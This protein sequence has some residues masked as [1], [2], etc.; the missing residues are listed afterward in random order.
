M[1]DAASNGNLLFSGSTFTT[2]TLN[3]NTTYYVESE[4]GS[5]CKSTRT[6]VTVTIDAAPSSPTVSGTSI[7]SGQTAMLTPS[8]PSGVTFNWYD[9]ASNG[10]LLFSGSTF[11]TPTLNSNTTYYVESENGSGCKSTRTSVTVTIDAAPSSPTV[12]GTSICSGQTAMLTPSAPS[13]VTFNWYDAASNG[14]LL[15]S[16]STFTTPTLNSNTTYYVESENGSGCKSTRTSVTVTI[17]AAPS[18]P[19]V[20]G[21]SICSGQTAMLTPSAPSGVTFNWYDAASNGNLLF[22]GSTFTTPTLN[23]N[24]TYY[25]ESENGSGC[26]STRTSVTVTIDAARSSPTV[27]GTSICS[28]QTAMLTPSAPSGVTFNWY[29]AASNGN[30]LFSGSTFTTPTLNSNTTYYVESENGSGCKSTRTSVTVTIDAAPSSPTVIGTSICSGQ[31][32]ML[33]PSAPSGVTFNWYDAASNGNLLFSG[34]TFTTPT[35]NSN[36]TYYVESENGSGCKS[37]R[38]SVT[39]T[40]DA[41]PSSPTVIGTSICS[42]QTAMLTP[43]APSG[44]TFNWY[45]AASNGNLLFSGSTFTT[46]TLNSNT[47]YYVESENGSGC[48]STRTSVTVTIDAAPSSPTVSGTSICSG[49]T[50]M[51][52]PS[53]PSGVTFNWYDAASNGNLLFSGSTFTTPTLNS[54]TTYYVESENGS[55]CKSTRTSV[56]VTI[57]AAPSS[58]TVSGTSICSGQTAMLTPSAPSGV[59]FNW[60][61]AASNGNLLF[62]GSTFTT[63]TLNSNTTYY[64]ESENGSGCKSTRTSVTVTIDAAPSSPTV[65]GTSICSGQTAMLTP[66]APSGVTFNWYDAASNGNLLFS[67]STFTTPTLNSNTTYYVESENGSGCKSTRTSVTVTIDAAPSSPTVIGTSICSGQTAMLTPSAPSGVTFN[68]YDAASNGN[69]LFSGSTFTTPTL[70]SNTTYYVESEN[71][72]GCKSTRTSV[73]VTID[74]APSSP[75]VSGTSICSG[76]TAMLTPSAP[77]GVTFNWYDAAS[78]GNLFFSGSTF[79]HQH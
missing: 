65:I 12:I 4:N 33:T 37:T 40:I 28:G 22:S 16:G 78:N 66:S 71:G 18:S 59:T 11:T 41:A 70:N 29:D 38:T 61:D 23:S 5:G 43:S 14:N 54:N 45:D 25:V 20:S 52:T 35:L 3:S 63:P 46:P 39:V 6:S 67:G 36:T 58:P 50:A 8:A 27:I 48:K 24:T 2:P 68:W 13:G 34:S 76:Q 44:V 53:A 51:L 77:S 62:S 57:D 17:D 49:Q 9:A 32:A 30:L 47:T 55:G 1:V 73:T 26:K 15:F 75:T 72:S 56:T 60:Y 42:G 79:T 31:T 64:V 69:L 21:T 19:T 74:A 7:C 10:N